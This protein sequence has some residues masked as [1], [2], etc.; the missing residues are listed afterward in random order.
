[1]ACS[2]GL[3]T[4]AGDQQASNSAPGSIRNLLIADKVR[5]GGRG[6]EEAREEREGGK[7][8]SKKAIK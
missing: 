4:P 5:R 7:K 2:R 1:M 6:R 3:L 8:F